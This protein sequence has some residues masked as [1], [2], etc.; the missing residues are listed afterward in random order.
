MEQRAKPRKQYQSAG[1]V[2]SGA[3]FY[4]TLLFFIARFF[5]FVQ[6]FVDAYDRKQLNQAPPENFTFFGILGSL[7]VLCV[8]A[9]TFILLL[10]YRRRLTRLRRGNLYLLLNVLFVAWGAIQAIGN[11]IE[12]V[13]FFEF[14]Y[15]LDFITLV[16]ALIIPPVLLQIADRMQEPARDTELLISAIAATALAVV[17]AL[18]VSLVLRESYTTMQLVRELMFRAGIILFGVAALQ[19]ALKLRSEPIAYT[20]KAPKPKPEPKVKEPKTKAQKPDKRGRIECP[21]CGKKVYPGTE[22]CP[23]CGFDMNT[24]SLFDDDED[25]GEEELAEDLPDEAEAPVEEE[26]EATPEEETPEPEPEPQ[27]P[28]HIDTCPRCGKNIPVFL[29]TCPHC[30][31]YPGDPL[32]PPKESEKK[33]AA[34]TVIPTVPTPE[35]ENICTKCGKRIPG[36]LATC[37]YCGHHPDDDKIPERP[38]GSPENAQNADDIELFDDEE[39]YCPRCD[40]P[41]AR[42]TQICP[43]CGY[44]F[45]DETTQRTRTATPKLPR[46]PDPKHLTEKNSIRC[47]ECGRRYS[48]ARDICPY[49]GFSLYED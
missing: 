48:A 4:G 45:P 16:A 33:P 21:D 14:V 5:T 43:H 11:F 19:K 40:R 26:A 39:I 41:V 35:E 12:M 38:A 28:T 23:R 34:P 22:R 25:D 47:P 2:T 8:I 46:V 9:W 31:Y 42:G 27:K 20:P 36:G 15:L 13:S 30:G 29:T 24:P 37:P 6:L 7:L 32:E 18:I 49:C 10:R 44:P 3:V 1:Y 17:A